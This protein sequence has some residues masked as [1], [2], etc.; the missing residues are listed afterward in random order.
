MAQLVEHLTLYLG[1]GHD[2]VVLGIQRPSGLCTDSVE[3]AWD[4]LSPPLSLSFL[5][6]HARVCTH[7]L[8]INKLKKLKNI[9][10]KSWINKIE[11]RNKENQGILKSI[12][13]KDQSNR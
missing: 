11:N 13:C 5:H 12:F 6:S 7:S 4:S 3:P 2:L 10:N 9:K 8:K 1:L